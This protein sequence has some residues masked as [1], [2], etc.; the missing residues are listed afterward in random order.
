MQTVAINGEYPLLPTP[1][2]LH[3]NLN[4]KFSLFGLMPSGRCHLNYGLEGH[5]NVKML[6]ITRISI[7]DFYL[8]VPADAGLLPDRQTLVL[9]RGVNRNDEWGLV[10]RSGGRKNRDQI[11]ERERVLKV[12]ILNRGNEFFLA[13]A[14]GVRLRTLRL[15]QLLAL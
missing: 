8:L 2:P 7:H 4:E 12:G 11:C 14:A 9:I 6:L 15:G 13:L 3:W 5:R 10:Y 1:V